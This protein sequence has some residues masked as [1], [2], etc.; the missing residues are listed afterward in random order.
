MT[1]ELDQ[2]SIVIL[3]IILWYIMAY[4]AVMFLITAKSFEERSEL[5]FIR[6]MAFMFSPIVLPGI[7][8]IIIASIL[9]EFIFG[10]K[11]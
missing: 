11:D 5:V 4:F 2:D 10:W 6:T 1:I 7:V 9:M 3:S 8:I